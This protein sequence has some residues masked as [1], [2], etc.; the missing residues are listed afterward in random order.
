MASTTRYMN[1]FVY[2]QEMWPEVAAHATR[3]NRGTKEAPAADHAQP[4]ARRP[5]VS[6][7]VALILHQHGM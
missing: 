1:V 3:H 6:F 2:D 7:T 5:D 4:L